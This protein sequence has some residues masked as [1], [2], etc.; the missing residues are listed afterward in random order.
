[1]NFNDVITINEN[2]L[3]KK[4]VESLSK[5]ERIEL[6]EPIFQYFRNI[7]FM[8]PDDIKKVDSE[9]KR[10]VDFKCNVEE[11]VLFNNSSVGTFICKYFC[12]SF[13]GS[14]EPKKKNIIELFQDDN[15]LKSVIQNRLGID[16]YKKKHENDIEAFQISFRQIVQGF[17]SAR[18]I[19]MISMFKPTIAKFLYERYSK[20]ND[21]VYD[22][23]MGFGGRLLGAMS[24]NRQYVGVDPLTSFELEAMA[25]HFNFKNYKLI[26][27][28]SENTFLGEN[29]IDFAMS[30]PPYFNQEVYS[31]DDSQAYNKGEDYFYNIYWKNTLDN[32]YRMLKPNKYFALNVINFPKMFEMANDKFVYKETIHLKTIRSHLNKTAGTS[33]LEPVYIFTKQ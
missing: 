16:W 33:K 11:D 8:Y 12:K 4:Y 2:K 17:R 13:F 5:E 7:G 31:S 15:V 29:T 1:M 26:N 32:V 28:V 14:T 21:I 25:K 24:C 30:S 27:G 22:Y 19:P 10:L 18:K 9:W 3:T 20:K 6:I 23:S